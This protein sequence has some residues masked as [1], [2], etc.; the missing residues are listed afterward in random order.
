MDESLVPWGRRDDESIK[1]F[2]AFIKYRDM[3]V[4][5]TLKQVAQDLSKSL[6]FIKE[7]SSRHEWVERVEAWD[8]AQIKLVDDLRAQQRKQLVERE[9]KDYGRTLDK[10][11]EVWDRTKLHERKVRSTAEDGTIIEVVALN[12]SDW[13]EL[14]KW[15]ND[16][17][18]QGRR[19][20]GLPDRITQSKVDIDVSKLSDDELQSII[21]GKSPGGT[22][23]A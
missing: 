19:A 3:G 9:L 18:I 16:I 11:D 20:L 7:W 12:V 5:R 17:S 15:R 22:G 13:R 23:T 6:Q 10:F 4:Q 21:E 8:I 1:A 14:T 2:E